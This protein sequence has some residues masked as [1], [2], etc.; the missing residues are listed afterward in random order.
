MG[1][2]VFDCWLLVLYGSSREKRTFLL[3]VDG[4][5]PKPDV[6]SWCFWNILSYRPPLQ[7][8]ELSQSDGTLSCL[9]ICKEIRN[10]TT[11][12]EKL[13]TLLRCSRLGFCFNIWHMICLD[14]P[15]NWKIVGALTLS[16]HMSP[17]LNKLKHILKNQSPMIK[18]ASTFSLK[19]DFFFYLLP[20]QNLPAT[21]VQTHI[22]VIALMLWSEK[23]RTGLHW[24]YDTFEQVDVT[25]VT[26]ICQTTK[27]GVDSAAKTS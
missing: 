19:L 6:Y 25:S 1:F 3:D 7:M 27:H 18:W 21:V 10:N 14:W 12:S 26:T 9:G 22:H 2:S 8:L 11:E 5:T 23:T 4:L 24:I 20:R 16:I 15:R 17:Q 13:L